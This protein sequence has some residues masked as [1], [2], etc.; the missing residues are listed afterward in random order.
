VGVCLFALAVGLLFLQAPGFGDEF[1]YW[2]LSFHLHETGGHAWSLQSYH[3]LRWPIWGPSWL[4]QTAFGP[5]LG[6]LYCVPLFYLAA[7]AI[8]AFALGRRVFG[9]IGMG[10]LCAVVLVFE[11]LIDPVIFRGM[12]DL[13]ESVF[14]GCAIFAWWRMMEAEERGAVFLHGGLAGVAIGLCYSNRPS[15]L[16]IAPVLALGT[17]LFERRR[18]ARLLLP[19][20]VAA[21]YFL[22]E[23]AVY[24]QVCGDWWHSIYA[25]FGNKE[26]K[27]TEA[28]TAWQLPFRYLGAFTHGN[29]LA[30]P[31]SISALAGAVLLW[32]RKSVGGKIATLWFGVVFLEL[33]CAIQSIHPLRPLIGGAV[34]YVSTLGIPMALLIVRG[35]SGSWPWLRRLGGARLGRLADWCAQHRLL[36]AAAGV[37]LLLGLTSRPIMNFGY[38]PKMRRHLD[39]LPAGTRVFTHAPMRALAYLVA[40]EKAAS[41]AWVAPKQVL[42]RDEALE[43][44]AAQCD[45][46]WYIRKL[47]WLQERKKLESHTPGERQS[48]LGSYLADPEASWV[49]AEALSKDAEPE[50]VFYRRRTPADRPPQ[51]LDLAP[52]TPPALSAATP[53]EWTPSANHRITFP[54]ANI[55]AL[56]N[57]IVSI[58]AEGSANTAE[59]FDLRLRFKSGRRLQRELFFKPIFYPAAG[60]EFLV[61]RVPPDAD[62]CEASLSFSKNTRRFRLTKLS[63]VSTP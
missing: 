45:E 57:R 18:W 39:S 33:S 40:P 13:T 44:Q 9:S 60:S 37:L 61:F 17:L 15:G 59:P 28:L 25:N 3:D 29:R 55:T 4:W 43:Q 58:R 56:Q 46:W 53:W 16:F 48:P 51:P 26:A 62:S 54:P 31:F 10:W 38:I 21:A 8:L 14:A 34:R 19:A 20:A 27:G 42:L 1:T 23:C 30:W 24:H 2:S 63:G 36:T 47:V 32:R 50:L 41:L 5:G 12:P 22:A 6:S 35:L 11:P 7:A 49:P 52:G